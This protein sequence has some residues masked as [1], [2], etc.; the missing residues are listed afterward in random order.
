M[1]TDVQ[2]GFIRRAAPSEV[3]FLTALTGRSAL[4]WGYEPEFLDWEP[5]AITVTPEMVAQNPFQVLEEAGNITG[6][7]GLLGEPPEMSLDKLFVEPDLIG[8]GRGKLLWQHAIA[9]AR[10]LGV[11]TLIFAADPNAAPFYRAMGATWLR[12]ESTSRP[13]WNLQMFRYPLPA[14]EGVEDEIRLNSH[15]KQPTRFGD[16]PLPRT[17]IPYPF[18]REGEPARRGTACRAFFGAASPGVRPR[19]VGREAVPR[20]A[21]NPDIRTTHHQSLTAASPDLWVRD[22]SHRQRGQA[23]RAVR[24]RAT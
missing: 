18:P 9:A 12:E 17:A 13:G 2:T 3:A 22:R 24:Q 6:Y 8:T 19:V 5:E 4:H 23:V 7:Y 11:T 15:R 16:A 14:R 21:S 1:M 10:S 20:P